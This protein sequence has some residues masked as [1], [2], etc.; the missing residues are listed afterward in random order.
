MENWEGINGYEV[1]K[2]QGFFVSTSFRMRGIAEP[3]QGVAALKDSAPHPFFYASGFL[4][5]LSIFTS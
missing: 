3:C 4:T 1:M 2:R 5:K